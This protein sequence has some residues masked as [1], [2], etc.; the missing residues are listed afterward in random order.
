MME[1]APEPQFPFSPPSTAVN[2]PLLAGNLLIEDSVLAKG[3]TQ[4]QSTQFL[5][6][7]LGKACVP[8]IPL[9]LLSLGGKHGCLS[10]SRVGLG[11]VAG[12]AAGPV[13]KMAMTWAAVGDRSHPLW[14]DGHCWLLEAQRA[15]LALASL[16]ASG[17]CQCPW[18]PSAAAGLSVTVTVSSLTRTHW[19]L[20][21]P[22]SCVTASQRLHG[23]PFQ[24]GL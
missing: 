15:N 23:I 6:S 19:V 24:G 11:R 14:C 12:V 9:P 8:S 10:A 17:G 21:P 4:K 5:G 16:L 20:V 3:C 2:Q 7:P 22:D 1:E 18:A 13:G